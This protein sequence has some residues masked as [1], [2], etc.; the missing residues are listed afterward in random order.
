VAIG[1]DLLVRSG[2]YNDETLWQIDATLSTFFDLLANEL[3][4]VADTFIQDRTD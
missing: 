1:I 4:E 3:L 2:G